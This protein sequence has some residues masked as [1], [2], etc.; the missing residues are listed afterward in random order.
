MPLPTP[1]KRTRPRR[2]GY[3]NGS[4][5]RS[6]LKERAY[7]E[8][9]QRIVDGVFAPST[10]LSERQL[11][12]LL[13]MSKTPIRAALE[14]LEQDG[15]ITTSPQQ[16][17]IVRDL[18]VHEI[19]DL[20]ELRAALEAYI[21][22]AVAGK[23]TDEQVLVVKANLEA[24]QTAC[25]KGDVKRL[26][27]VDAAFHMLFCGFLGNREIVRTMAQLRDKIFR[28]ISRVFQVNPARMSQSFD[29]HQAIADAIFRGQG[30]LAAQHLVDHLERGRKH[31]LSP[32]GG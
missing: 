16:G 3:A 28:V 19:A 29:E 22:R 5:G 23:L 30:D 4:S 17:I 20:Y 2:N 8:I 12:S 25:Y 14:R 6:L 32:R 27:A 9:K 24:Q 1:V 7:T 31:L 11:A 18:S 10:F 26:V 21:A 13:D 15:L